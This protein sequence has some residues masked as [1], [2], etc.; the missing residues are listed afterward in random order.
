MRSRKSAKAAGTRF[1]SSVASY[2]ARALNDPRIERRAKSGAKDRG[3]VTGLLLHG[4]RCVVECKDCTRVELSKWLSEAETE[5]GND[6]AAFGVVAHKRKGKGSPE[7][8]YVTM[9]LKTFA[10]ICAGGPELLEG[11]EN[12]DQ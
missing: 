1:E 2:L 7:D 5:R 12:G 3:D 6:D 11:D 10:A 8:Q 4:K 9:T